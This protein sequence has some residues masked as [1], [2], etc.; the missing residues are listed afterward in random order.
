MSLK[1]EEVERIVFSV[2]ERSIEGGA[3]MADVVYGDSV[4][5]SVSLRNGNVE[6]VRSS[7]SGGIG[8]RVVDS[9]GAQGLASVNSLDPDGISQMVSWALANCS[10]GEPNDSVDMSRKQPDSDE[11]DLDLWDDE[12]PSLARDDR[13]QRCLEMHNRASDADG[14][15][16]SI[17]S[18]SWSDGYGESFYANSFGVS[19]WH[20]GTIVS[21][22]MS[23]VTEDGD[24]ME[25][26]GFGDERRYL[27]DL[28]HLHIA[29]RAVVESVRTLGG[30]PLTT[31]AY[32]LVLSPDAAS[33]LLYAISD[34]F[35]ASSIQKNRSLL[36]G[37][38]GSKVGASCLNLVDDGRLVRGIGSSA[39][40]GEGVPCGKT[41]LLREGRLESF[42]YSLEYA[43]KAGVSSTGN[44]FRG[45]ATV[46]DV[47]LSNMYL[48]PDL[49]SPS[50]LIPLVSKGLY[51]SE[52]MGLHTVNSVTGEF[53]LG[54]KGTAIGSGELQGP[55]S[56]VTVAGNL[57]D[58]LMKV[59]SVGRDLTFFGDVGSPSLVVR[60]VTLAGS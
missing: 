56:G 32:D 28:D 2:V 7:Q 47:D 16:L 18:S 4:S 45:V 10:L 60:D 54:A 57:I 43:K 25:M 15:I 22:G 17:R 8:L 42:L 53:S 49:S 20:R 31:G 13:L 12:I 23:L 26:G 3:A 14:R 38:L 19:R 51:V 50:S 27:E 34:M 21:A 30:K 41:S 58:L 29:D 46:P 39:A 52:L 9:R 5:R 48:E 11:S 24:S 55:V 59:S 36:R 40:D 1:R 35:F 37:R 33:S 6:N 44:G